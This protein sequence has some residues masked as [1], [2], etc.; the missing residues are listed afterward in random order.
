MARRVVTGVVLA[1]GLAIAGCAEEAEPAMTKA[2]YL[3]L[4]NEVCADATEAL[5]EA[6]EEAGLAQRDPAG[7]VAFIETEVVPSVRRQIADLRELGFPP[8]DE[9]ELDE[10]Y[11]DAEDTLIVL[12]R[13]PASLLRTEGGSPFAAINLR[14]ADYGL[15]EC[16]EA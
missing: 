7:Q 3:D 9:E 14:L 4:G 11:D 13:D 2:E 10:L 6:A 12:A 5:D 1:V 15:E 8:G 16:S